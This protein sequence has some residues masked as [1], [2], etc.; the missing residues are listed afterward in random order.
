MAII[1][2]EMAGDWM[3]RYCIRM[4]PPRFHAKGWKQCRFM[5][6]AMSPTDPSAGDVDRHDPGIAALA[7]A[8][9][10]WQVWRVTISR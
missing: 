3:S 6:S 2:V 10:G 5:I 7:W 9:G 4:S 8:L 1:Q